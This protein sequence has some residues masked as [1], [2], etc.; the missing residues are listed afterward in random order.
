MSES[1]R[2][3][4]SLVVV[5]LDALLG[6]VT[7][8]QTGNLPGV[9]RA[10]DRPGRPG[11]AGIAW[12]VT[13]V[14]A[15]AAGTALLV[16]AVLRAPN[17]LADLPPAGVVAAPAPSSGAAAPGTTRPSPTG[18]SAATTTAAPSRSTENA[19]AAVPS[20]SASSSSASVG[21]RL[22]AV[23]SAAAG[24]GLLGYRATVTVESHGPDPAVDWRLTI[25]LPR[26]T[27]RVAPASGATAT[28]N[29]AVWTFTPTEESRR[30]AA[31][32]AVVVTYDV[33]GA[34]LVDAQPTACQVDDT[35]CTGLPA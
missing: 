16:S 33:L 12:L 23:Y 10:A 11:R 29:G 1:S 13:G 5:L 25:T 9:R 8:V 31:G 15:A 19:E 4:R 2:P 17:D 35:P 18:T 14:L 22:T 3:R 34:T 28:Q 24:S 32:D 26:S 21:A 6:A 27:L 20:I 7:A 30:I